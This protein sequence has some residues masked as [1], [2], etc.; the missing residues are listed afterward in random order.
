M[1]I[2]RAA[3]PPDWVDHLWQSRVLPTR[4]AEASYPT[5]PEW[6]SDGESM[7]MRLSKFSLFNRLPLHALAA[8]ITVRSDEASSDGVDLRRADR[9]VPSRLSSILGIPEASALDGFC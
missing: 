2:G 8:L 9:F 6:S 5:R 7:W 4:T 1:S 3:A